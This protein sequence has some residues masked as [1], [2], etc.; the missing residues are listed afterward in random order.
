QL[1]S[2]A[3]QIQ[4]GQDFCRIF[5]LGNGFGRHGT[6]KIDGIKT[7]TQQG[8]NIVDFFLSG[9][10]FLNA[11]HGISRAFNEFDILH[12]SKIIKKI[13]WEN[14]FKKEVAR[15]VPPVLYFVEFPDFRILSC[16]VF[17]MAWLMSLI[18]RGPS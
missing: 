14:L 5:H 15:N 2:C 6:T 13:L 3:R 12:A 9:N 1:A 7:T 17:K 11:L 10:K 16:P 18:N 4:V 8:L